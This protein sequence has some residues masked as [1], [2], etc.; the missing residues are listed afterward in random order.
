ML[1]CPICNTEHRKGATLCKLCGVQLQEHSPL[2]VEVASR[3]PNCKGEVAA[4]DPFCLRCGSLRINNFVTPCKNHR[5]RISIGLCV[6]CRK[7]LCEKCAA[8]RNRRIRCE[9]HLDVEIIQ[10]WAAVF[11]SSDA[12]GVSFACEVLDSEG[13]PSHPYDRGSAHSFIPLVIGTAFSKWIEDGG[14]L[15]KVFVPLAD[16]RRAVEILQDHDQLFRCKCSHCGHRFN[17]DS[18]TQCPKCGEKL[19]GGVAG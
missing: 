2:F 11:D 5:N 17:E 8:Q 18:T 1:T 9:D 4:E 12:I 15:V 13:I 7:E 14:V 3:C 10:D 19:A 6:L 16:F